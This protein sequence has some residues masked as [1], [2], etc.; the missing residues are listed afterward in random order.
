MSFFWLFYLS[1]DIFV[2]QDTYYIRDVSTYVKEHG[3]ETVSKT[4]GFMYDSLGL[5]KDTGEEI[6]SEDLDYQTKE[7]IDEIKTSDLSEKSKNDLINKL[8]NKESVVAVNYHYE[9]VIA[10]ISQAI[11]LSLALIGIVLYSKEEIFNKKK[12]ENNLKWVLIY[13]GLFGFVLFSI[14]GFLIRTKLNVFTSTYF[15][16]FSI[17]ISLMVGYCLYKIL[18]YD[19]AILN[20]GVVFLIS[21][22]FMGSLIID[23]S[24]SIVNRMGDSGLWMESPKVISDS[25]YYSGEWAQNN[26]DKETNIIGDNPTLKVYSGYFEL[27]VASNWWTKRI[28]HS[29]LDTV[30]MMLDARNLKLNEHNQKERIGKIDVLVVNTLNLNYPSILTGGLL[31]NKQVEVF[32]NELNR[33][34]DN[35]EIIM[36]G[37][38]I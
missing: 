35:N 19:N 23:Y 22:L 4:F 3:P 27:F 18:D 2:E 17:G 32:D 26:L 14:C 20:I 16:F 9:T 12:S 7:K 6:S 10:S 36:Y 30:R 11:L 34:Y 31:T 5:N 8:K 24:P 33:I 13:I 37:N 25:L 38:S 15:W 29:D 21:I 1:G 28:Y